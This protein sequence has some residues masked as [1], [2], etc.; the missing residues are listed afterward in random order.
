LSI[1]IERGK[2]RST[3]YRVLCCVLFLVILSIPAMTASAQDANP[4][5]KAHSIDPFTGADSGGNVF[6]GPTLPFGMAKPGPDMNIGENDANAGWAESGDIGGFNQT[7]VSGTGGGAKYGNVLIQPTVGAPA[8]SGYDSP[9]SEEFAE[10]GLYRVKLARYKVKVELT[11]A[12]RTALYRF[13]YPASERSNILIDVGR[14]LI[15]GRKSGEA[16]SV[17]ASQITI[18]SPTEVTGSTSVTGGWNKQPNTYTVYFYAKTD[19]PASGW[20]VWNAGALQAGIKKAKG[21]KTGGWLTFQTRERQ[22]IEMKVGISFISVEQAKNNA[23]EEVSSFDFGTVRNRLIETWNKALATVDASGE[24]PE[25]RSMLYT[26]LYHSMIMPTDRSGENPLWQSN[27]PYYDDYYAIW[28]TF[29]CASPLLTLIAPQRETDIVRSL[30]DI[31]RHEG[32]LPDARSGNYNGRTQGG[33]NA[34]FPIT[35]AFLKGLKGIDWEEAYR[36]EVNDAENPPHDQFKEGRGGLEDWEK[37]GYV[38]VEG[39]DRPG[40]KQMEYAA[41]DYEIALLAKGLAK[42][43]DTQK[44]AMRAE[45]WRKLWDAKLSDGGVSGF[46]HPRHRDGSWLEPFTAMDSGSWGSKTFY[47]GNSWTY[48]TFVPQNVAG[49][50][51]LSGS[52]ELFVKRLDAFFDGPG[53]YDV[54]NEPGFLSPYLY[55]WAGRHDKTAEHLRAIV[56]ANFHPGKNGMAF[57]DDSGAMSAWYALAQIG[58]YPNAG[59]DVY[60][61]GSPTIPE[62]T[63]HLGGGR[64]FTII[65]KDVSAA[66]KYVASAELNGKPLNRAWFRQAEIVDGGKL[67]LTMAPQPSHWAADN[68]PPSS[69]GVEH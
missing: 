52:K 57:N 55:I 24:T 5:D 26:A 40:S 63:I 16:Q 11:A 10:I 20:G 61:I 36:A 22:Q 65:A 8:A 31:Y 35:D 33:S 34:E 62:T 13:T 39:V 60:L 23:T 66:N 50:I 21:V 32:W 46:I 49:V 37:S 47:E 17:K 67:V 41:D 58:I 64:D 14:C 25:Q 53:R 18:L 38:S 45:N 3:G 1:Y 68:E 44:Y 28:D 48:S 27:E 12:R 29:R 43:S 51:E 69:H 54:G 6:V 30:V 19:T 56:A 59:Q 4:K 2:T 9:R 42:N 7:H 15:S